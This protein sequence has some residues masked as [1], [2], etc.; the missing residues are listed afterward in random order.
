MKAFLIVIV[1]ALAACSTPPPG[2]GIDVDRVMVHVG[3]MMVLG[4][5]P[6][7]SE[8]AREAA[9][10]IQK[11][12]TDA[13]GT[14]ERFP[15]GV[16]DLPGISVMGATYRDAHRVESTDPDLLV[17]FG[18]PGKVLLIMAHY[19][20]VPGSPGAVDNAVAVGVLI[21]LARVLASAHP[22]YG[23]M[24]AFTANEE[25]GLVGAEALAARIADDVAFAI[26]L[27]LIGGSGDLVLNGASELIGA[28]EM[29][30][31]AAAAQ[32][33]GIV[34]RAPLAHRVVSRWWPQ[35]ERSDHGPFTRRGVRAVHF[36]NRGQDGEWIDLAYHSPGDLL[37]RVDRTSVDEVGR[38]LFA[39]TRLPPPEPGGADG[40]WVPIVANRIIP[41]AVLI[42]G[43]LV[44]ALVALGALLSLR[45]ARE[46]GGLG[47]LAGLLCFAGASGITL[48]V[49][50]LLR[51]DHPAPWLHA[52]LRAEIAGV[53]VL[54][55][56]F[57]LLVMLAR[58][59]RPWIGELRYLAVAAAIP[60]AIGSTLLAIGA[61]ELA[62]IWLV[63]AAMIALAP[64]FGPARLLA[65]VAAAL[66]A[67]LVLTP[68]LLREAAF[69]GFLP[70]IPLAGLLAAFLVPVAAA[71][72]WLLR[73]RRG[74]GPLGAF[75]LPV[76]CL[77]SV[78]TG[79]V[80]VSRAHPACT[81]A[82]FNQF[83]LACERGVGVR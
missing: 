76:G 13:G 65:V 39:L 32:R 25:I 75:V 66:P 26:A 48:A 36:Y 12:V 47:V 62:W 69:N 80:L 45:T 37:P 82:D 18:P 15:V 70:P 46:R 11:A 54:A 79:V 40:F 73:R 38:L 77:L 67:V 83:H 16:V 50:V 51:G 64:R 23:V 43:E 33:A 72:A 10:Y 44:L 58:R 30:W 3:S 56:S 7:D 8:H 9:L 74:Q 27:D 31:L 55:G 41:R 35:A 81:P 28:E 29:R 61:A 1:L 52:P 20:T 63:P 59:L 4:P 17:R 14:V 71:A 21:E 6:G 22:Q 49:E 42:G 60:L 53:L 78:V 34:V 5:R 57:G 19:D 24:L 68:D 2:P